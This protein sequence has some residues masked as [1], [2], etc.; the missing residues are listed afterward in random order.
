M[1][2]FAALMLI[3]TLLH[4]DR[5]NGGD[6][7]PVG[8]LAFYGWV[9]VYIVAPGA[10]FALWWYNRRTVPDEPAAGEAIVSAGARRAAQAVAAGALG[11]AAVFFLFPQV[12]IDVWAWEL[13][14]LTSRVLGSFT[15]QLGVVALLLSRDPRWSAWK[16]T[17]QTFVVATALLLVGAV[18]AADDF[19]SANVLTYL[20]L[21]GL[22]AGGFA[23]LW[24]YDRMTREEATARVP[25]P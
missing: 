24:L 15:A 17:V 13:T 16:L 2:F 19:E 10:I 23:L 22:V 7:P 25:T 11:V 18:R 9:G 12:A 6:A 1:A 5:F 8:A 14:P 4:W 3:A 21:G 20:F